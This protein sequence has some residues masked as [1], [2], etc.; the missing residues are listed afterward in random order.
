ML[1]FQYKIAVKVSKGQICNG[2]KS[3]INVTRSTICV[4]IFMLVSKTAQG[5][6]YAALLMHTAKSKNF[7]QDNFEGFDE[8]MV[9]HKKIAH[10]FFN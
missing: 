2:T 1:N 9:I 7:M 8:C 5:G 10:Q 6:Y 4:E 3:K